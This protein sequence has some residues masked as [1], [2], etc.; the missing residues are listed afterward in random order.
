MQFNQLNNVA[1]WVQLRNILFNDPY[2]TP[3]LLAIAILA[4]CSCLYL[5]SKTHKR[6]KDIFILAGTLINIAYLGWRIGFTLPTISLISFVLSLVLVLAELLGFFKSLTYRLLFTTPAKLKPAVFSNLGYV[7]TVDI[8]IT[9][10]NEPTAVIHRTVA[11]ATQLNYPHDKLTIYVCDDGSRDEIKQIC[12]DYHVHWITREEHLDA[13]AG[14]L[15]HCYRNYAK[16]EFSVVLDADMV[17]KSDFLEKTLGYFKD[18]MVAFV[19]TP[20][21][22]YNS[23]SFQRNLGLNDSISNEQDF[24]MQEI[25]AHRQEYNA[26]IFVGSGCVFRRTHLEKIGFIPTGS[27]TED[28]ATSLL[29]QNE[30]FKGRFTKNTF[31]LGL[32]AESFTDYIKQRTRWAQGN[33]DILKKWNPWKMKTLSFMQKVII[34]DG[35]FYW[36]YGIEKMIFILAPMVFILLGIPIMLTNPINLLIFWL[37]SFYIN[38][39]IVSA[40][41][42]TSRTS[43]WTHIYETAS[44]PH[45]AVAA[46]RALL[47]NKDKRFI[48]TPKGHTQNRSEF[49]LSV[50]KPHL[51][52]FALSLLSL[53][54]V[55]FKV[56]TATNISSIIIYVLNGAWILY[57]FFA[58][59]AS[60]IICFEKPRIRK[61]DRLTMDIDIPIIID[62]QSGYYGK[63]NNVSEGGCSIT[64]DSLPNPKD[65][66]GRKILLLT[67]EVNIIGTILSYLP[68]KKA[69][70]VQFDDISKSDYAKFVKF[71]FSNQTTGF[72]SLK[73]RN[74]FAAVIFKFLSDILVNIIRRKHTRRRRS[75]TVIVTSH[76]NEHSKKIK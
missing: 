22:F 1:S 74:A 19:Q 57:N 73:E 4:I 10:Y 72:G 44:A 68:R 52:L 50:A 64:P 14:N 33:I 47:F 8:I 39:L 70:A 20:Q 11:G 65:F 26:L 58:I 67:G 38:R 41:S 61:Y 7:P 21:V 75:K 45:L 55:V 15:N 5:L 40:F 6:I 34:S 51:T 53:G 60:L 49:A 36:F 24:F 71:V 32:S 29:L 2:L 37:P 63:L 69:Y 54:I 13:K 30:G 76:L 48:V 42:H 12:D 56:A 46:L 43:G 66:I 16:S 31:A 28:L 18:D 9:T 17:P 27:I 35:I 59:I 25:Q 23:D 3:F 62:G